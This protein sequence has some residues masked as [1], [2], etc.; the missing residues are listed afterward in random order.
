MHAHEQVTQAWEFAK[1]YVGLKEQ[2][3][4][5]DTQKVSLQGPAS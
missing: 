2:P 4:V 5:C 1:A 3:D